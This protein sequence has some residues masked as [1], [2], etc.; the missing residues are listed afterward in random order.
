MHKCQQMFSSKHDNNYFRVNF[1][2]FFTKKKDFDTFSLQSLNV[3]AKIKQQTRIVYK[4]LNDRTFREI[5][6]RQTRIEF[7]S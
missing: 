1:L 5:E 6:N 2:S 7:E 3:I 4:I